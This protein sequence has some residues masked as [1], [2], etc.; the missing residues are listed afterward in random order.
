MAG[1]TPL[2]HFLGPE[3]DPVTADTPLPKYQS[4]LEVP[5]KKVARRPGAELM[6]MW[7][8]GCGSRTCNHKGSSLGTV[9]VALGPTM[10]RS[11]EAR[12]ACVRR[13]VQYSVFSNSCQR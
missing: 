12:T 5:S 1:I 11:V 3:S 6:W 10:A 4:T 9:L 8:S 2:N 7:P 13:E